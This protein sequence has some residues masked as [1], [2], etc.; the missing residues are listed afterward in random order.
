MCLVF[1][2]IKTLKM[3]PNT[4]LYK[5]DLSTKG[6]FGNPLIIYNVSIRL[7]GSEQLN[8]KYLSLKKMRLNLNGSECSMSDL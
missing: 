8:C 7:H 6:A 5:D 4:T 2:F 1:V 3:L